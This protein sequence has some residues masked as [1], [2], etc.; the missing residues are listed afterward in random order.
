MKKNC[1]TWV[2]TQ[3]MWKK[4]YSIISEKDFVNHGFRNVSKNDV[5]YIHRHGSGRN[6]VYIGH[7]EEV[8]AKQFAERLLVG[9]I[10]VDTFSLKIAAC[11]SDVFAKELHEELSSQYPD[12]TIYGYRGQLVL[13]QGERNGKLAGLNPPFV[14]KQH[15]DSWILNEAEFAKKILNKN[16]FRAKDHRVSYGPQLPEEKKVAEDERI[17]MAAAELVYQR[18]SKRSVS[19][20][21]ASFSS[22]QSEAPSLHD[23][24]DNNPASPS[25]MA[26][27]HE[28][29]SKARRN[30]WP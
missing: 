9:R 29:P 27:E 3:R 22:K 6:T 13:N 20:L 28:I 4:Q 30:S 17:N 11:Y 5:L 8:N 1:E 19:L 16:S 10:P 23:L 12:L 25:N 14:I 26:N 21:T 7:N 15:D 18:H 2:E 24:A